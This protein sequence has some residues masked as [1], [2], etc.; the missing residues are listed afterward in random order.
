M[1]K[2]T[3]VN[4][5]NNPYPRLFTIGYE[6]REINEF[7]SLIRNHKIT[8]LLDVRE[9]PLSRKKGFSKSALKKRLE[10][11]NIM[12]IHL[13]RLGSPSEIRKKLKT[14]GDYPFYFKAFSEYLLQNQDAIKEARE[15]LIDG[16]NCIMCFERK[17][18]KCHR[19]VIVEAIKQINGNSLDILN[20]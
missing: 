8:R 11:E 3:Q 1:G 7:I 5:I 19:S 15:Y 17:P 16:I 12:Y 4:I 6:G 10:L 9:L 20:I 14:D 13:R 18:E 2:K